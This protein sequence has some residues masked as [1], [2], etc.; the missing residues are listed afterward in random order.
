MIKI[1]IK[2][3]MLPILFVIGIGMQIGT[4]QTNPVKTKPSGPPSENKTGGE[5]V[6]LFDK[7]D[8]NKDASISKEEASGNQR[9][10]YNFDKMDGNEDGGITRDEMKTFKAS[11]KKSD[12]KKG[13]KKDEFREKK[14]E[15]D[16]NRDGRIS[17]GEASKTGNERFMARFD[18]MDTNNDDFISLD[19]IKA[20]NGN[21]N[22]SGKSVQPTDSQKKLMPEDQ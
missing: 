3:S 14:V 12:P 21:K 10:S 20:A 19:E 17:R 9:F 18:Q 22:K 1:L 8:L 11:Q 5:K 13:S 16:T 4:S 2:G 7:L 15:M 6:T